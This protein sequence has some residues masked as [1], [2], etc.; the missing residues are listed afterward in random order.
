MK[1]VFL[2]IPNYVFTSDLL[3]TEYIKY[4]SSQYRTVVI[5][6]MINKTQAQGYFQSPNLIYIQRKLENKKFWNFFKFLRITLV[7]EFDYLASAR[8]FYR[9]PNYK[10]NWKRRL[11]RTLGLPFS[12]FFTADRFTA[13]ESKF[14]PHS[15]FFLSLVRQYQPELVISATPGFDPWEAEI[16]LLSKRYGLTTVAVNFSW[17]N[18]TMNSKHIRKTDFLICWNKVMKQEAEVI[19]SYSENKVFVSG[20]PRFD[21]YFIKE[22]L[23]PTKIDFIKSK[24]LNP[25]YPTIL[26][27]TVTKAYPFQKIYIYDLINLRKNGLIPYVNLFIRIHPLDF[28][29]NYQE[30]TGLSDFYIEK[31]GLEMMPGR[32]EMNYQDLLNLKY[33][34]KYTDLNINY[35]STISI[36]ACIFDKP[37]INIGYLGVYALAYDFDH[38]RPICQSG[39]I[40]LVKEDIDLPRWINLYFKNPQLDS[41]NRKKIVNQ[42]VEFTDGFAYK[43]SVDLLEKCFSQQK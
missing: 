24:G 20:T 27:T 37:I 6:P 7:N 15:F 36:E 39:A 32:V 35:A 2:V 31:S 5:T 11:V 14:L 18:L 16:I 4:L 17:D 33:S 23:E 3:R 10:N 43:R 40:R 38:Y 34:L 21:P 13:I 25:E 29:D 42:Y 41:E 1:T 8:H 9:R 22:K 19:H 28:Y 26:Y 12:R 30:F